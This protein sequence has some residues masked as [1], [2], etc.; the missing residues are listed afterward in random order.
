MNFYVLHIRSGLSFIVHYNSRYSLL[1]LLTY[2]LKN[3]IHWIELSL[4][5]FAA[6]IL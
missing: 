2:A 4:I 1:M 3:D 5:V 6:D